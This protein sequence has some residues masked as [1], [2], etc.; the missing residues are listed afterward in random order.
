MIDSMTMLTGTVDGVEFE[1][2]VTYVTVRGQKIPIGDIIEINRLEEPDEQPEE[3]DGGII[4]DITDTVRGLGRA[5][6]R[7]TPFLL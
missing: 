7:V 2:G 1:D 5:A 6:L 4:E 3:D